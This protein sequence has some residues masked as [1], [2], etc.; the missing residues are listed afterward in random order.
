VGLGRAIASCHAGSSQCLVT[1]C[2]DKGSESDVTLTP[3]AASK[4]GVC[5]IPTGVEFRFDHEQ[6]WW[7][8]GQPRVHCGTQHVLCHSVLGTRRLIHCQGHWRLTRAIHSWWKP[9]SSCAQPYVSLTPQTS[10]CV[11]KNVI[12]VAEITGM[13]HH[14]WLQCL[15]VCFLVNLCNLSISEAGVLSLVCK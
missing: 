3:T 12:R 5:K 11:T 14:T 7:T 4:V 10:I 15:F 13:H 1:S 6:T 9:S 2:G 8:C